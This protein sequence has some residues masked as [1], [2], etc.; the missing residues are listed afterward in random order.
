MEH[1]E[2]GFIGGKPCPF[3]FH[4]A[5]R[6]HSDVPV[7]FAAPGTTPVFKL[8]ELFWGGL[9][10]KLHRVLVAHPVAAGDGAVGMLV[11][12]IAGLDHTGC[13]ALGRNR[14]ASHRIDFGDY[15]YIEFGIKL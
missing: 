3:L 5:E 1:V 2:A 4:S 7:R 9:N 13:A 6:P 11:E 12:C 15:G 8:Q 14:M 10:E